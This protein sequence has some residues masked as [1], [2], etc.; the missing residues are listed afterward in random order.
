MSQR[1]TYDMF[2][3]PQRGRFG[4]NEEQHRPGRGPRI[5]GASDLHDL[6]LVLK[7]EKPAAIAVVDPAKPQLNDGKWIWLPKS[8]IEWAHSRGGVIVATMPEWLASEKGFI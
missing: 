3:Q 1:D 2:E 6:T 8:Q 5:T 7:H 4:E